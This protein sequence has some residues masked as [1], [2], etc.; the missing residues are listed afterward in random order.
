VSPDPQ[1]FEAY[2]PLMFSIAYRMLGSAMEAED[3][4][5]E[6]YLRYQAVEAA[7]IRSPKAYLCQIVTHLCLD[8]LKSARVQRENYFGP[9]L[10]EPI[11]TAEGP[12]AAASQRESIST[13]FLVILESL[14]PAERAVFL[15][16]EVFDYS[17]AEIAEMLGKSE[18]NCRQI[19]RRARQYVHQHRPR[20]EPSSGEQERLVNG[21]LKAIDSGDVAALTRLLAQ[22]V[23]V[24]GDGGGKVP[25]A[26][27]PV[28][29]REKVVPF[30]M[31]VYRLLPTG[32]G[33][34][35]ARVNGSPG[36]LFRS[37]GKLL[38]VV[39]FTFSGSRIQ[40]VYNLLNPEKLAYIER[41]RQERR[42]E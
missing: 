27:R 41:Q 2:R 35:S 28:S 42:L 26:P 17:Y 36:L 3:I 39:T 1:T 18:A 37:Q 20:F 32:A 40:A 15:L 19:G 6:A 29:G 10:P 33:V 14:S 24:Y 22:D 23:A 8:Q 11:L 38:G 9:W 31:R 5:Q 4:L 13:A 25:A 12:R 21:F 34:E 7:D 16:R 30:L